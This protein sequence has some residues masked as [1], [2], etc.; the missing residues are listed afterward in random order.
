MISL[1]VPAECLAGEG[2]VVEGDSH[3]HLFRARRL[4]A[5]DRV[6]LADGAG[7][8]RWA[9]VAAVDKKSARLRL[10][11][12]APVP[13]PAARL[14]LL[15]AAPKKERASWLIEKATELGVAAVRFMETERTPREFGEGT[16]RRLE[17][18]AA[19]AFEQCGRGVLPEVSGT[20]G[21]GEVRGLLT[22]GGPSQARWVLDLVAGAVGGG[23]MRAVDGK[24]V[25]VV[26]PEGGWTEEEQRVL[27]EWGCRAVVLGP[28]VLR[29]ETAAVVGAGLVING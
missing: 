1:L 10:G 19:A 17:R 9:E 22:A 12:A 16:L 25:V 5:G 24:V 29:V 6:R 2:W 26:G 23:E 20:H 11:E 14:T 3:R 28:T 13:E 15:V 18:V 27:G 4:A 21:W 7:A 8:A